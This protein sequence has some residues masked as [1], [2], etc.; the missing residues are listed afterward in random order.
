MSEASPIMTDKE[1]AALFRI[2]LDTL[3]RKM[4]EGFGEDETDLNK[5]EPQMLGRR[6]WW[7]RKKV[8]ALYK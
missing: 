2:S 6:R 1:V 4:R 3:Q 7:S 5:A 8:E